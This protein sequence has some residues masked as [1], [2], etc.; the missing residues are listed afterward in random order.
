[1][2]PT[3]VGPASP[4]RATPTAVGKLRLELE[5]AAMKIELNWLLY[6]AIFLQGALFAWLWQRTR[7]IILERRYNRV[8]RTC[9]RQRW[10]LL[11]KHR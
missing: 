1:M 9:L 10:E 6:A 4:G 3:H 5:G 2:T 7:I 11:D 8:Y